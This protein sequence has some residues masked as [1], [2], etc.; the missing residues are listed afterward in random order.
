MT[1]ALTQTLVSAYTGSAPRAAA[2]D[3]AGHL[4]VVGSGQPIYS[5]NDGAS[6]ATGTR[7]AGTY[8]NYVAVA[9]GAGRFVAIEEN[10]NVA[11]WSA[12]G[13]IT[14]TAATLPQSAS[15]QT[16]VWTGTRF[17]AAAGS[18]YNTVDSYVAYSTDGSVW[19]QASAPESWSLLAESLV[20]NG[21]YCLV[22]SK[23]G[24]KVYKSAD[25]ITWTAHSSTH[26]P[27]MVR[28]AWN[29][30]VFCGLKLGTAVAATSGD[31]ITWTDRTL[32]I[33]LDWWSIA[34]NG[35]RFFGLAGQS[36]TATYVTSFDGISWSSGTLPAA[37]YWEGLGVSG[38]TLIGIN[39]SGKYLVLGTGD[40]VATT[41]FAELPID[42]NVIGFGVSNLPLEIAVVG[43]GRA[44]VPLAL[45]VVPADVLSGVTPVTDGDSAATW[46]VVVAIAGV[47]V[48]D[49]VVG[50]IT[51]EAEEGTA[52]IADLT[53]ELPAGEVYLPSWTGARVV[54][55]L[56]DMASGSPTSAL[57]LFT[58]QVDLPDI[59]VDAG[60]I[61]LRCTDN[62]QNVIDN[63]SRVQIDDLVGGIWSPVV[64]DKGTK[65]WRYYKD[66]A[67]TVAA[68]IDLSPTGALR[69]T[70]WAAKSTADLTIDDDTA[71]E[72][73]VRPQMA[74]RNGLV[75]RIDV[76]FAYRAPKIKGE[77]YVC[78]YDIMAAFST[79]FPYW[80][81]DGGNFLVRASVIEAIEAAGGTVDSIVWTELP[82]TA[83]VIPALGGGVAGTWIPN[84]ATD[85]LMCL[86][87]AA[88][89]SFDYAQFV[90]ESHEI[91]IEAP[92][93]IAVFGRLRE[94]MSGALEGETIDA[95]ASETGAVLYKSG[96][97][98]IP[99]MATASISAGYT[100]ATTLALTAETDR[101][102][103]NT[104]MET[105]IAIGKARIA[106]TH[107]G[108]VVWFSVPA[109]AAID[110]DKTLA[111]AAQ[112]VTAR[113][114]VK[115][116]R[117]VLDVDAAEATTEVMLAISAC[118]G[119]GI[120]HPE[121]SG[122]TATEE[123]PASSVP[124]S[125]PVVTWAGAAGGDQA[126]TITFPGVEDTERQRNQ[127]TFPR[128]VRAPIA[129]DLFTITI[130]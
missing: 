47:D 36:N 130:T 82:T 6:W 102:A 110:V 44:M 75:N 123:P 99:P 17:V 23:A 58:G 8:T 18:Y 53:L 85:P 51:V 22:L 100:T 109:N 98:T 91:A 101:A 29:G 48:T 128:T 34:W 107:R 118:A 96:L 112:G 9:Y 57:P 24:N 77:G 56:A 5:G 35:V 92:N 104:A 79:A 65:G 38:T 19:F 129:E 80:V 95:V 59:D 74:E 2:G 70:P 13:G 121:D 116:L 71:F 61:A 81:R 119:L 41:G 106:E 49:S 1:F 108:H 105:L 127:L 122:T 4:V 78:A 72:S 33:A 20:W 124:L 87:F 15:W 12:D 25:G 7:P 64:F 67:S 114:K 45:S 42:I 39:P 37:R 28:L 117:H 14:W 60:F 63:L 40:T 66:R 31:G 68:S 10:S 126:I 16:I 3:G 89:V 11:M 26:S 46:G 120:V 115:H 84:P 62:L 111:I 125:P 90:D 94:S 55:W 88:V 30:S 27:D 113:G 73:T 32:P 50:Q 21:S 103:A 86:G 93:S 69:R 43:Y 76:T 97:T 83:V 52:R 54:I